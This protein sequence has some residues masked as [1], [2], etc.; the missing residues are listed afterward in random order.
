MKKATSKKLFSNGYTEYSI[1][2]SVT[3]AKEHDPLFRL[4]GQ[5]RFP[6]DSQFEVGG[7]CLSG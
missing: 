4:S 5:T 2:F 1:A 6:G 3:Q 7:V